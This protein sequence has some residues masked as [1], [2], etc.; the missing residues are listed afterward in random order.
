MR[1]GI[2]S[3]SSTSPGLATFATA[4]LLTLTGFETANA[5][6]VTVSD[7]LCT[8]P[9]AVASIN[10]GVDQ[11]PCTHSGAYKTNDTINVPVGTFNVSTTL[12][13]VRM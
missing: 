5:A 12:E 2:R 6:T 9:K 11:P 8:L 7:N 3:H 4:L 10:Y 1:S 13:F